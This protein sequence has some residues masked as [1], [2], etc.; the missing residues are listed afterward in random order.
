MEELRVLNKAIQETNQR[1]NQ[2]GM[3][4]V[5][6]YL[7]TGDTRVFTRENGIR[8]EMETIPFENMERTVKTALIDDT[9][10]Y[11]GT[12][13]EFNEKNIIIELIEQWVRWKYIFESDSDFNKLYKLIIKDKDINKF[14]ISV[15][16]EADH[17]Y[18][19]AQYRLLN[20]RLPDP[21]TYEIIELLENEKF[22]ISLINV[23]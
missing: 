22:K 10:G 15:L 3:V 7:Q 6:G 11:L 16:A 9:I 18:A 12:P 13:Q 14:I 2:K 5:V 21:V 17:K 8:N 23:K 1:L 4:D 20:N 19:I